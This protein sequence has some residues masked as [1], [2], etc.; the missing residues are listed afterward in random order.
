MPELDTPVQFLLT[1]ELNVGVL[2]AVDSLA[3]EMPTPNPMR[4]QRLFLGST[5]RLLSAQ[6]IN[7]RAQCWQM[8]QF[9]VGVRTALAS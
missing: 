2:T 6:A 5:A 3:M 4:K 1:V 7:F 9:A 8:E